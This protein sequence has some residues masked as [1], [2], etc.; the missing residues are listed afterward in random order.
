MGLDIQRVNT[1]ED[2]RFSE[3]V[4]RQHG[5]FLLGGEPYEVEITSIDSAVVRGASPKLYRD[6][7]EYFRFFAGHI[8]RFYNSTGE[9]VQ[10]FPSVELSPVKL[11][12]IQ[13]SQFYV[14][15]DKLAAVQE[16]I[17]SAEDIILPVTPEAGRYISQ[18][19][20]TRL[21][22][23][24]KLGLDKVYS[25]IAETNDFLYSFVEEAKRRGVFSPYDLPVI[26]HGEYEVKWNQFCEDFFSN[27][28]ESI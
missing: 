5:A 4:L 22:A 25:F 8:S 24:V 1:Y 12:A 9:L 13:P 28:G 14:D 7:I 17:C 3:K 20:H 21:A 16:F 19:G 11:S 15:E 23:A 10:Q 18:D 27:Q 6:I 26:P 2:S